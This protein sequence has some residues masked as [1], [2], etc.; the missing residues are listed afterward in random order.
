MQPTLWSVVAI[1][2]SYHTWMLWYYYWRYWQQQA[3]AYS[4]I[5]DKPH[6]V[7]SSL[8]TQLQHQS[9]NAA[10][11]RHAVAQQQQQVQQRSKG[12]PVSVGLPAVAQSPAGSAPQPAA[13]QG[14]AIVTGEACQ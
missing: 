6:H 9:G 3:W 7:A 12:P 4:G 8:S 14:T 1:C 13:R 11:G 2:V 10:N 5:K